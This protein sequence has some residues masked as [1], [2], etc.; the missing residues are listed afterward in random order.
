MKSEIS[1]EAD[2]LTMNSGNKIL[3]ICILGITV[4]FSSLLSSSLSLLVIQFFL[5]SFTLLFILRNDYKTAKLYV[6]IFVIATV[7]VFIVYLANLIAFGAPYYLGGSDDLIF[8]KSAIQV[9]DSSMFNDENLFSAILKQF[10]NTQFFIFYI[11]SIIKFT[12]IFDGYSTFIPRILNVY[13]L[14]W[15]VMILDYLLKKY[16]AMSSKGR[17]LSL[18]LFAIAPNILYIN[19]HVFRD[20]FNLLQLLLI[21]LFFDRIITDRRIIKKLIAFILMIIMVYFVYY[22]RMNSLV[23]VGGLCLLLFWHT[24]NIKKIYIVLL[25]LPL[26]TMSS[27]LKVIKLEYFIKTYSDYVL[28]IAGDGLSSIVF[29]QPLLPVGIILR[30]IYG[31]MTPFPNFFIL[32]GDPDKWLLDVIM[33]MVQLSVVIQIV[34]IPFILKRILKFDWL[35]LAF[36]IFFIGVIIT[37]FTFR[38]IIFYYPFLVALA[39]DGY[40]TSSIKSRRTI[41]FLSTIFV[42][43]FGCIYILLKYI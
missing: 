9:V 8:E 42:M 36:L 4:I 24:F 30:F 19:A 26:L 14:V 28:N 13:F 23:F 32:F 39:V 21:T 41:L 33:L 15:I 22:T 40:L 1:Y 3:L 38:H 10:E 37:T 2:N 34:Y 17:R 35:S 6:V 20:I 11:A 7:F 27:F 5:V 43:L 18:L 31:L 29:S 12:N 16:T 25:I